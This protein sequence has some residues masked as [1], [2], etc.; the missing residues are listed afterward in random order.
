MGNYKIKKGFDVQLVGKPSCELVDAVSA[1]SIGLRPLDI[2]GVR[3]RLLVSEGD[4]VKR[5]AVLLESKQ[6]TDFKFRATAAGTISKIV[7]GDRRFVDNII[8][9]VDNNGEVEQLKKYD[10]SKIASLSADVIINH[11]KDTGLI[12]HLIQR[13]FSKMADASVKP[14]SIFVNGMNTGPFLVDASV[15]V[16]DAPEAFQAGIDLLTKLTDGDVNLCIAKGTEGSMKSIKNAAIH[17]F[18]GAH[19]AGN[20]SLHISKVDPMIPTDVIW[21]I[22]A[23]ELVQVGK[24]FL[25]GAIPATKIVA[26]GGNCVKVGEAKHYRVLSGS[27]VS[28]LADKFEQEGHPVTPFSNRIDDLK[29]RLISGD[30]LSGTKLNAD[31]YL[32]LYQNSLTVIEDS[33][34]RHFMGW[35]MPG[36]TDYSY[37]RTFVS[38]ILN[39][40]L[41]REIVM[42]LFSK[43][44][45]RL[46][47]NT[48][49]GLRTMVLTGYYDKVMPLNIMVDYLIRAVLAGDTDEAIKLGILETAPEDFALCEFICPSKTDIQAVIQ[50]GLNMIEE[51]G[52]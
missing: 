49:G 20:T 36:L 18:T 6:D 29:V 41:G 16:D 2:L 44:L 45:T 42:N 32:G 7:L 37:S 38:S 10:L 14:K 19:P 23:A 39:L 48:N 43:R 51:E 47:T 1:A 4:K 5:G 27:P 25:D 15:V 35:A 17:T 13:P 46:N 31:G 8:I 24:V 22:N 34:K 33:D 12:A 50:K 40:V 30:A 3:W 26:L 52:I 9:D 11:L 28:L 21:T